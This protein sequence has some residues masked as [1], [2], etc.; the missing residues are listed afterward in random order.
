MDNRRWTIVETTDDNGLDDSELIG[1]SIA[2]GSTAADMGESNNV[3]HRASKKIQPQV[4]KAI[5][6][7]DD[8]G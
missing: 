7:E 3:Y 6:D 2:V 1:L 5:N 4:N 8:E